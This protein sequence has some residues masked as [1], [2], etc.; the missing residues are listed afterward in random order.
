ML[1]S[2]QPQLCRNSAQCLMLFMQNFQIF[3]KYGTSQ[4]KK[5]IRGPPVHG[6]EPSRVFWQ[7]CHTVPFEF[8]RD[9]FGSRVEDGR[10]RLVAVGSKL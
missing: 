2:S 8:S 9:G 1:S 7:A 5:T 4:E 10:G 6:G 3:K